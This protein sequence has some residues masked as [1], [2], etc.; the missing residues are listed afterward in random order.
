MREAEEFWDELLAQIEAGQVIPVVGPELLTVVADGHETPLY[1][2]LAER[3][4]AKY[5]LSAAIGGAAG[6]AATSDATAT[7]TA[8]ATV[9]LRPHHELNDAV[10]A[11]A[12]RGR[13][14]QDLYRPI[15]DL[16]KVLLETS[17]Q[18][19]LQPLR[20]VVVPSGFRLFV[21]TT[22]DDL[23]TRAIDAARHGGVAKTAQIVFAPARPSGTSA[24][25]P[26]TRSSGYTAVCYLFGKASPVPFFAIHDEDTLEFVYTLQNNAGDGMKLMFSELCQKSLLLIGC[27]FAD[28]LSRLF[29]RLSNVKRL[30]DNRSKR[31]FLVEASADH[32]GSLT[33]FLERFSPDTWVFP[34]GA[35]E[36][37]AEL[38]RRWQERHPGAAA[39]SDDATEALPA[40]PRADDTLFISY[41]ST[42]LAAARRLFAGLQKIGADVAWFDKSELKPGD[43]WERKIRHAINGCYLFLPLVSANTETREE[44]FFRK[45]WTLAGER[46]RGI[47]GRKFIIPIV[48]DRGYDGNASRYALVPDSFPHRHFSHAPDGDLNDDLLNELTRLIRERR[49]HRPG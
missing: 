45:E 49:S 29:I 14:V 46:V 12:H 22:P 3:L 27:N 32:N 48:V 42:D 16:L 10:C 19:A 2:V 35:R 21:T 17:A 13:R 6:D 23:L 24:D 44:G 5:G 47:Q 39:R 41:S 18:T 31:E 8:T 7:A 15:D 33:L 1:Q 20:D 28:W 43:D 9:R 30:A 36:F 26:E 38:A 40:P 4:L 34:G 25:L 37:A 11:L